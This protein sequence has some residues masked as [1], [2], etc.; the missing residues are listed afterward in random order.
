MNTAPG[1]GSAPVEPSDDGTGPVD[2]NTVALNPEL[3]AL[4]DGFVASTRNETVGVIGALTLIVIVLQLFTSIETA[5]NE[6]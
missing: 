5:F 4:I 3:I 1:S 2:A 6:I